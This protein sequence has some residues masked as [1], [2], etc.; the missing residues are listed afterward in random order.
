[1]QKFTC[2]HPLAAWLL[3]HVQSQG[4]FAA[5]H[6]QGVALRLQDLTRRPLATD[7]LRGPD[8]VGLR[9]LVAIQGEGDAS[10]FVDQVVTV[11]AQI[12]AWLPQQNTFYIQEEV[13]DHDGN[14]N[15][16]EGIAVFYTG[17]SPITADN[18]G[19]IV[20]FS[21][22]VK[23]FFGLTRLESI[24]ALTV[25]EYGT[26]KDLQD[27]TQVKLPI[28]SGATLEKYEGMLVEVS[29]ATEGQAL[30]AGDTFGFARFGEVTFFADSVPFQF[31]Q[32]NAPDVEGNAAYLDFLSRNSIQLEDGFNSQNPTLTQLNL[33]TRILRDTTADGIDN[34][35]P[36][37][38]D[39]DGN[40][41]FIRMGDN[42]PA[43]NGV[44]GFGFGSYELIATEAVKLTADVRP[45]MPD[46]QAINSTGT[47]EV[48]VASFNVL[49]YFALVAP[50][51]TPASV[52]QTLN[53]A[54]AMVVERPD[55]KARLAL[56]ALEP[57]TGTPAA[58]EAFLLKDFEGWKQVVKQQ[59]LKIDAF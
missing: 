47:A 29:S 2:T 16:S 4:A 39:A 51:G 56:D 35:T 31:S 20:E 30:F 6:H 49:N 5:G 36:L 1:M 15:T 42:T 9:A 23:E 17:T 52:V 27:Y 45:A 50:R 22:T 14:V 10:S 12:T 13:R 34:G 55:V 59:N 44:L 26:A 21:G 3:Q 24:S 43:L 11:R 41:N 33:G 8:L 25:I 32:I 40:V 38:A 18:I 46:A 48:R 28:A 54:L 57:A 19:D 58:L 37:G 7:R 53:A